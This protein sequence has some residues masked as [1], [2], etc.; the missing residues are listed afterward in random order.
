MGFAESFAQGMSLRQ[1]WDAQAAQDEAAA[2]SK[3]AQDRAKSTG[4]TLADQMQQATS[5]DGRYAAQRNYAIGMAEHGLMKPDDVLRSLD[6]VEQHSFLQQQAEQKRTQAEAEQEYY[7]NTFETYS[8]AARTRAGRKIA[9]EEMGAELSKQGM[10][11]NKRTLGY[12]ASLADE[13]HDLV[14]QYLQSGAHDPSQIGQLLAGP[15]ASEAIARINT[16]ID[17]TKTEPAPKS[18]GPSHPADALNQEID[19]AIVAKRRAQ[20]LL[21]INQDNTEARQAYH[22]A[23]KTLDELTSK[24]TLMEEIHSRG[25]QQP[26]YAPIDPNGRPW[27]PI[28]RKASEL[29]GQMNQLQTAYTKA[30]QS[31]N[32]FAKAEADKLHTAFQTLNTQLIQLSGGDKL[33][34]YDKRAMEQMPAFAGNLNPSDPVHLAQVLGN[35]SLLSA[36]R[37]KAKDLEI[38]DKVAETAA[39]SKTKALFDTGDDN[40]I[41]R[42]ITGKPV[43]PGTSKEE[44]AQIVERKQSMGVEK[45]AAHGA[46]AAQLAAD[47]GFNAADAGKFALLKDGLRSVK[48]AEKLLFASGKLDKKLLLE[49]NANVPGSEGRRIR[50]GLMAGLWAAGRAESGGV[51]T[52]PELDEMWKT[53]WGPAFADAFGSGDATVREKLYSLKS[54]VAG[55]MA[56]MDPHGLHEKAMT[57]RFDELMADKPT[58]SKEHKVAAQDAL[59]EAMKRM[60]K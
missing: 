6:Q 3:A 11:P 38:Q 9:L 34:D 7:K 32:P 8:T 30:S 58:V 53:R 42:S 39:T 54:I 49:M 27:N 25:P 18:S 52:E 16:I 50:R 23:S 47:K 10:T 28:A 60:K 55:G 22:A 20:G 12:I 46:N 41:S 2:A 29:V 36:I 31:S 59:A 21:S 4:K 35:P 48:D 26:A 37:K 1:Q 14:V 51:I 24:H 33:T 45:Q 13:D 19:R 57:S 44:I 15:K 5:P 17:G 56:G 40:M 43:G